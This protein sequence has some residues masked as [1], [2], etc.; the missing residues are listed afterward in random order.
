MESFGFDDDG[1]FFQRTIQE[2]NE[3]FK[4]EAG[5]TLQ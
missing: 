2:A 4:I 3:K 1:F 5:T